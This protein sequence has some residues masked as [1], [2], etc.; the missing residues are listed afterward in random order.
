MTIYQPGET[1]ILKSTITKDGAESLDGITVTVSIHLGSTALLTDTAMNL[2]SEASTDD[3]K[4]Y[5]YYYTIPSTVLDPL[6]RTTQV[7][8]SLGY[9]TIEKETILVG[10]GI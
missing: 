1:I 10:D 6:T 3:S 4:V 8:S 5:Y 2:D 9:K 7:T